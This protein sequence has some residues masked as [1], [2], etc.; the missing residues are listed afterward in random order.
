MSLRATCPRCG[1]HADIDAMFVEPEAKAAI[2]LIGDLPAPLGKAALGYLG[3][4]SPPKTGLRLPKARR[5]LAELRDLVDAGQ[6]CADERIGTRRPASPALWA[7]AI[8]QMLASPPSG[9]PLT[10]HNYLRKV[11]FD[12][13][14]K[15]DAQAE[16]AREA[17]LQ[18]TAAARRT[19]QGGSPVRDIDPIDEAIAA[20]HHDLQ[21]G[22]IDQDTADARLA[23]IRSGNP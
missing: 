15:V 22:F 3:L 4:H 17:E 20:V 23:K 8:E 10:N 19:Q 9:L 21:F 11:V 18:R 1:F 7:Q 6:V 16:R 13:A 12:L 14:D 5:L 2:A